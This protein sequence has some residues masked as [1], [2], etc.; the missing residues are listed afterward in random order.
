MS[1]PSK[2]ILWYIEHMINKTLNSLTIN[3][4]PEN[5]IECQYRENINEKSNISKKKCDIYSF[6]TDNIFYCD[7]EF[8]KIN[9]IYFD[10]EKFN[11]YYKN[12]FIKTLLIGYNFSNKNSIT[13][14]NF[15]ET[16]QKR[17]LLNLKY[18][19]KNYIIKHPE[20]NS[21]LISKSDGNLNNV[22]IF[23][24]I[25]DVN[26]CY[27]YEN[28]Q[29]IHYLDKVNNCYDFENKKMIIID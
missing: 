24:K 21:F 6:N 16:V 5:L 25:L 14:T 12:D 3:E 2:P 27:I 9:I 11:K 15:D 29:S 4:I 23:S 28:E 1:R 22:E 18:L 8:Y 17:F 20:Y 26:K 13:N 19:I 10:N 7:I